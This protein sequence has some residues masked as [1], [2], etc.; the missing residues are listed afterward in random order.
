MDRREFQRY[1][2]AAA[3]SQWKPSKNPKFLEL[4]DKYDVINVSTFLLHVVKFMTGRS[5]LNS[6]SD[7]LE[8]NYLFTGSFV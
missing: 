4:T 6:L 7:L 8:F 1:T 5:E 2:I 3:A